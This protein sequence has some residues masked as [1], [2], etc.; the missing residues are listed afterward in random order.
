MAQKMR[1][2]KSSLTKELNNFIKQFSASMR[3]IFT[4]II[5]FLFSS[6]YGYTQTGVNY[7]DVA[8]VV[9]MNS[10][11]SILITNYF[12]AKRNI[13]SANL[14][15]VYTSSA[16]EISDSMFQNYSDQIKSQLAL[17]GADINYIVTTKGC[18]LKVMRAAN[19]TNNC[20]SSCESE[21]MLLTT[22]HSSDI[23]ACLPFSILQSGNF[24]KNPYFQS[25]DNFFMINHGL[26]LVTRLDGYT[27]KDVFNM[28]DRSGPN[29]YVN[30]DSALFILDQAP[31]FY[32]NYL[33]TRMIIAS[34]ILKSKGW[35]VLL[36]L[37]S[38]FVTNQNNV[39]G[40]YS[41]GSND[42]Y[43]NQYTQHAIPHNRW[44]NGSIAETG[45]STGGRSFQPGTAYGQSLIADL[46]QE[47]DC[48]AKGYTYEP[49]DI[50]IAY[51]DILFDH[52]TFLNTDGSPTFNLAESYFS[53]SLMI[54]WMDVVIGDPK[55]S[56][57]TNYPL[58]STMIS[59]DN[60]H[61]RIFP[62]PATESVTVTGTL[63]SPGELMI[64]VYDLNGK[65]I[66]TQTDSALGIFQKEI[67]I[68]NYS[69][70][71]YF[72]RVQ[73]KNGSIL[74]TKFIKE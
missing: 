37:D 15:Q 34:N 6:I 31:N 61:I 74:N 41:W 73:E 59:S 48:G 26:Y 71:I 64:S 10:D 25:Y 29:T 36:N 44:L 69:A 57:T 9:N 3:K 67:N 8:I 63:D 56:I 4:L 17:H 51:S 33:N 39:L 30:K 27:V 62:N 60:I 28:I 13:P 42:A 43:A 68:K 47:G 72:I 11:S 58:S 23:G 5:V 18:P 14:I 21:L 12:M 38:V 19:D 50:S 46:L 54:G 55:T 65:K 70:G 32:G 45:V 1:Q 7:D 66:W 22:A 49:F 40:Y 20:N 16:E 35:K 2:T 53:A 24:I 52:Y